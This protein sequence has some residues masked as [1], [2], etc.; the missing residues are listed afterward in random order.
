M[1]NNFEK[2]T[3]L[4]SKNL[5]LSSIWMHSKAKNPSFTRLQK[6]LSNL[7]FPVTYVPNYQFYTM[8]SS[9]VSLILLKPTP[10]QYHS[11]MHLWRTSPYTHVLYPQLACCTPLHHAAKGYYILVFFIFCSSHR[12]SLYL[13]YSSLAMS[14][15]CGRVYVHETLNT[16]TNIF[17]HFSA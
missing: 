3:F 10:P 17:R 8:P 5:K 7:N 13:L 14:E 4:S 12:S 1:T 16:T 11:V 6:S 15:I 9:S 2:S